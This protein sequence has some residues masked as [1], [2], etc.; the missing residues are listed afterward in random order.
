MRGTR[1][2]FDITSCDDLSVRVIRAETCRIEIPELGVT[3]EPG[4]A[5]EGFITNVEGVLSR[6][7]KVIGMTMSWALGDG[8]EKKIQQI[9]EI[10]ERIDAVKKGEFVITLILEDETGNSAILKG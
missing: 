6:I 5:S 9:E 8:D 4:S 2:E 1:F 3:I 7:E 10:F